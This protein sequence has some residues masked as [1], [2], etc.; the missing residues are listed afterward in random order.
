MVSIVLKMGRFVHYTYVLEVNEFRT[1]LSV[2]GTEQPCLF[3]YIKHIHSLAPM[4]ISKLHISF[5]LQQ[6]CQHTSRLIRVHVTSR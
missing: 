6:S 5:R 1:L 4:C 2:V 3:L